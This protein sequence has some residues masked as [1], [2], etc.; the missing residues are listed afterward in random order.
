M[1]TM[2]IHLYKNIN[3]VSMTIDITVYHRITKFCYHLY[4]LKMKG[5]KL[6]MKDATKQYFRSCFT[7]YDHC[8]GLAS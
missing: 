1:N 6:S 8:Y 3:L 2:N 4:D 7:Y 5:T